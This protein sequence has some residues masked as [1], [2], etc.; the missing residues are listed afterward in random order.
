MNIKLGKQFFG[1]IIIQIFSL[2]FF[3]TCIQEYARF[4][5]ILG[6]K[7]TL[8]HAGWNATT[9]FL[10]LLVVHVVSRAGEPLAL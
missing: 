10:L 3:K 9:V 6:Q 8:F 2:I 5:L 4:Q 1:I 7:L